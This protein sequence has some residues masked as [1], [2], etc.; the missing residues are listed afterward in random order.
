M[1]LIGYI[2]GFLTV[3]GFLPQTVKTIRT[4]HAR[5]LALATFAIIASSAFFWTLYGVLKGLPAIWIT[6]TGILICCLIIVY[7]KLTT[8]RP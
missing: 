6:N 3:V 5:D 8:E 1:E 4:R 2:A 7:I